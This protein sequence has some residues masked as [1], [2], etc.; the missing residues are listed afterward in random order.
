VCVRDT[1]FANSL[2]IACHHL[3]IYT[4]YGS[5]DIETPDRKPVPQWP[6]RALMRLQPPRALHPRSSKQHRRPQ[7]PPRD[8]LGG[9][10]RSI[11]YVTREN[12]EAQME[13]YRFYVELPGDLWE[14]GTFMDLVRMNAAPLVGADGRVAYKD[15]LQAEQCHCELQVIDPNDS[16]APAAPACAARQAPRGA[17]RGAVP[18][19]AAR[20]VPVTE[21]ACSAGRGAGSG[22]GLRPWGR[23]LRACMCQG[24]APRRAGRAWSFVLVCVAEAGICM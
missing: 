23:C 6:L 16:C 18:L 24:S 19:R 21:A 11:M 15:L 9:A 5:P 22:L 8:G 2:Y 17:G 13:K 1:W 10:A 12:E 14:D 7:R 4:A 3:Y 20:A